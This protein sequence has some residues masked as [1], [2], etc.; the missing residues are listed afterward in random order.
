M[1]VFFSHWEK[2]NLLNRQMPTSAAHE[3]RLKNN[4]KTATWKQTNQSFIVFKVRPLFIYIYFSRLFL[5]FI[6]LVEKKER[7]CLHTSRWPINK[8]REKKKSR[9]P[10]A[11]GTSF[12]LCVRQMFAHSRE[13]ES[14][15][16]AV[17]PDNWGLSILLNKTRK[18]KIR[19]AKS[20]IK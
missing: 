14:K 5:N 3:I 17:G 2:W 16:K 10:R 1:F 20:K 12:I 15:W 13:W 4:K 11:R 9:Y 8:N 6:N 7:E 19:S 18:K